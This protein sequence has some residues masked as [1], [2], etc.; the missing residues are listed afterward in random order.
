MAI[1][2]TTKQSSSMTNLSRASIEETWD[3][4]TTTWNTETRT[5]N[6]MASIVD[7]IARQSNSITNVIKP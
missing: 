6:D 3:S 2:N 4:N 1:V 5:W 7:N